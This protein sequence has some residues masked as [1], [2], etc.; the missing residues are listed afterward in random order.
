[1]HYYSVLLVVLVIA[2]S[3]STYLL[4][5][6]YCIL[7]YCILLLQANAVYFVVVKHVLENFDNFR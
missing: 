2:V 1:M 5:A 6:L 4:T 7:L 3:Y